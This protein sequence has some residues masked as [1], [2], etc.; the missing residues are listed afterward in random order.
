MTA[1]EKALQAEKKLR[2]RLVTIGLLLIVVPTVLSLFMGEF[3]EGYMPDGVEGFYL[4]DLAQWA[5]LIGLALII[6]TLIVWADSKKRINRTYCP[7]CGEQYD[8][9]EDIEWEVGGTKTSD[10]K[11]EAVVDVECCCGNCGHETSFTVTVRTAFIDSKGDIREQNLYHEMKKY[12]K[13]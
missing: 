5:I 4:G 10:R 1:K 7:K 8:Y 9:D 2:N 13:Y 3:L 6:I 12:F 11:V